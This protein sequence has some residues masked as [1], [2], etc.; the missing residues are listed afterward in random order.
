[1]ATNQISGLVTGVTL[2]SGG[3]YTDPVTVTSTG[4]VDPGSGSAA[5]YALSWT[6]DNQG[7]ISGGTKVGVELHAGG[8]LTN[9]EGGSISG[10]TAVYFTYPPGYG[11]PAI[12]D[13]SGS[14]LGTAADGV[15]IAVFGSITNE[16]GA[17]IHGHNDGVDAENSSLVINAGSIAG[18]GGDGVDF[19]DGGTVA[20]GA[21]G[22][23]VGATNG[24]Y[25]RSQFDSDTSVTNAAGGTIKGIGNDGILIDNVDATV[26]NAGTI[27]GAAGHDAVYLGGLYA[28]RLI[29]DPGAVFNGNVKASPSGSNTLELASAAAAGTIDGLGGK[30]SGFRDVTIDSGATWTIAGTIDGFGGTRI[31]GFG[32]ADRLDLTDLSFVAGDTAAAGPPDLGND[33]VT[34]KDANGD[35]LASISLGGDFTGE[36][37]HLAD[38]GHGGTYIT[39]DRVPCFCRGTRIL[40]DR[41]DVTV[42]D[43]KI[44]DFLVTKSGAARP[45]RWIG[46][47][48]Y[49]GR[50]A[51]GNRDVL[52]VLIRADA[53][54]VNVP[55]SD[56]WVSPLHAM[57]LG[58]VLIPACA[59]INGTSIV[60]A[61]SVERVEYFHLE[62][63]SHDVIVAEGALA[64]SFVDD[65]SRALFQNASDYRRLYPNAARKPAKYCAPIVEDGAEFEVVRR[66]IAARAMGVQARSAA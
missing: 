53:L 61:K 4:Q 5:L 42:E 17:S 11:H 37:F 32:S 25:I 58:G 46:K 8:S 40:T 38:D 21:G 62:L 19:T 28:S 31:D 30:Y 16:A 59:L 14:I 66:R 9:A 57:Y 27:T 60:Q 50:F 52:P 49:S 51:R 3:N 64:E 56:L 35:L 41:G 26:T 33:L 20:N 39:E 6:I 63:D 24:I 1:M 13:N 23:I 44:G 15:K 43:L 22:L 2:Q 48:S 7:T 18:A 47:R 34:I 55:R 65:D 54:D 45:I 36:F 10:T 29:V 12:L